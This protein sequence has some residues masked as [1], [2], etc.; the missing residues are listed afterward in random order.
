MKQTILNI[1]K[2]ITAHRLVFL[3]SCVIIFFCGFFGMPEYK[4]WIE[5]VRKEAF[6]QGIMAVFKAAKEKKAIKLNLNGEEIILILQQNEQ[7]KQ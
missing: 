2:F 7:P 6:S 4:K 3:L 1:I 5:N